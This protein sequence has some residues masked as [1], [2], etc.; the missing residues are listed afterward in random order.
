LDNPLLP[1]AFFFY[2]A[3]TFTTICHRNFPLKL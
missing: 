2:F 3:R 1:V